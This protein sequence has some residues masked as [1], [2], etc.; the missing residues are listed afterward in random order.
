MADDL[1]AEARHRMVDSQLRPNRVVDPR[2]LGVM[3]R[4]PRERFL[5]LDLASLAYADQD[6]PCGNGR[7]LMQPMAIA[8]LVQLAAPTQGERALVVA[9]GV[10]YGAAVLAACG[11][12]VT[13]L[14][15]DPALL[16]VAGRVLAAVAPNV[17]VVSGPLSAGW[18]SEAPYDLILLEGAVRAIPPVLAQQLRA[19]TGRLVAVICH[20]G[21]V[22]QAVLAE[23]T[24]AGLR[25]QPMFDCAIPEL[26]SLRPAPAFVF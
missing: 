22:S 9:A 16:A 5:P 17:S 24:T 13:A 25:A 21:G 23:V 18:P 10:G 4:L 15:E 2:I 14:E 8:R 1:L 7:V 12:R 20:Q 11:P 6:V 19:D 3:R 26:P